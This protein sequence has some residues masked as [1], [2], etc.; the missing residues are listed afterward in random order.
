MR[1]RSPFP[2]AGATFA[3]LLLSG[4]LAGGCAHVSP[5]ASM[6]AG[7]AASP[8]SPWQPPPEAMTVP[9]PPPTPPIPEKWTKQGT[10]LELPEILDLALKNNPSTR[11]AWF[12]ARAA[13]AALGSKRSEYFPEIDLGASLSR[14]KSTTSFPPRFTYFQTTYGPSATLSL[15]LL[16]FGGRG[17]DVEEARQALYSADWTHD[18]AIQNVV[19]QVEQAYYLYLDAKGLRDAAEAAVREAKTSYDSARGR[20]DAGIATIADVLQAKTALSQAQLSLE[21]IAGQIQTIR[22]T[23]AT[24]LGFPA[25]VANLPIDVG[26]LPGQI[27]FHSAENAVD[28]LI[29]AAQRERPDLAAARADA[30]KAQAH[31]GTVRSEGLP[32]LRAAA[33]AN[34]IYYYS[35]NSSPFYTNYSGSLL[36]SF[37]LFTGFRNSYDTLEA[38]EQ[39]GAAQAH[40]ESLRQQVILQVWTSY[41]TLKTAAQ[42]VQTAADL[43]ESARQSQDVALGRYKNGVGSILDLLVAQSA[44]ASAR[45]QEIQAR[46]DWFQSVAQLAHDTGVL[47]KESR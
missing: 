36:L 16:D 32:V 24:A 18:A 8:A 23:L 9:A 19:L 35:P 28:D 10:T 14:Q 4:L 12:Q 47:G 41:F 37:P 15:L 27:D 2:A 1:H 6:R 46:S 34:R 21:T 45:A 22:G 26:E 5:G 33:T 30:A 44:L 17:G 39:A 3:A 7:A 20:H 29:A 31:I 38:K 11:A 42:R 40:L 13:A 25:S 43:L